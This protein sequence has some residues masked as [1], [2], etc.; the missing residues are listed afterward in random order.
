MRVRMELQGRVMRVAWRKLDHRRSPAWPATGPVSARLRRA[1]RSQF[2]R[3]WTGPPPS[4]PWAAPLARPSASRSRARHSMVATVPPRSSVAVEMERQMNACPC[5]SGC[6]ATRQPIAG[7]GVVRQRPRVVLWRT[8]TAGETP[9][10]FCAGRS[11]SCRPLFIL[12]CPW[13]SIGARSLRTKREGRANRP[14]AD[15][16]V[17]RLLARNVPRGAPGERVR[18]GRRYKRGGADEVTAL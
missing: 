3:T 1:R 16:R 12:L 15:G 17:N 8:C 5:V 10:I 7:E 6:S 14:R 18:R 2:S 9:A 11:R 4:R 13:Q